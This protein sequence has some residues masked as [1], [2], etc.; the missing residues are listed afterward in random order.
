MWQMAHSLLELGMEFCAETGTNIDKRK[1]KI[2]MQN[3]KLW[4]GS[5]PGGSL[6]RSLGM[7]KLRKQRNHPQILR[8]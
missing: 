6:K 8:I 2:K 3:A 5:I 4:H 7:A 1:P